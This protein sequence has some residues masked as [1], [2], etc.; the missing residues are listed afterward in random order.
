MTEYIPRA[1]KG[2]VERVIGFFK[3]RLKGVWGRL[4]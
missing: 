3:K 2:P 1:W 4:G